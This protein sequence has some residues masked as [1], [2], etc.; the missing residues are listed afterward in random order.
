[1]KHISRRD[2][3]KLIG[4]TTAGGVLAA[5]APKAP[6]AEEPAPAEPAA[7]TATPD[8]SVAAPPAEQEMMEIKVSLWD[9]QNSFPEGQEPDEIARIVSDKFKIKLTPINVGWGDA[10]EKYNTWAASGQ[11]PDIIGAIAMPGT[12]RYY[13]WISDGVVRPLPDAVSYS[14]IGRLMEQ[15][16]LTAFA[17]EGKN[18]F[19]PRQTYGDAA[20]WAMDRGLIA[21]KDWL[22]KL[23]MAAPKTEEDYINLTVALAKNDPDGNGE[24]D[25]VGFVPV[26]PW[27]LLSQGWTG[28]GYT[29]WPWMRDTDGKFRQ[30][31][32]GERT[33]RM[34]QFFKKMFQAGGLDPDFATLESDQAL[35][36]F[37]SGKAGILGRQVSPK[38]LKAVMDSWVKL[39]P[40]KDFVES[41]V[42]LHGPTVDGNYTR[43]SEKAYWSESYIEA[44]VDDAKME[45][46]MQL[47]N[48]LYSK[49]GMY[50]MQFG[51][52]QKDYTIE[53]GKI[54]LLTEINP[55]T[56][57]NKPTYEIYP[58]TYAMSYLAAWTGDLVQYEDPSIPEAIRD[59]TVAERDFRLANWK[60]PKIDWRVQSIDV[61]EKQEMAAIRFDDDW[62]KFIMDTSGKADEAVYEEMKANWDAN[63]Y[64]AAV[65]AIADKAKS[66]GIE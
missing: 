45:R 25:T 8:S 61:P 23:G 12:G 4:L 65:N 11:L 2:A 20:W 31:V 47:Y 3:L 53:N 64:G 18:Y 24:N 30:A 48:F 6:A 39:Q 15:P 57:L 35:E 19:L 66:M 56:G 46:I 42:I 1:M 28:F 58:F 22:D 36:K 55:E 40:D 13:Q 52:D 54:K 34:M 17:V 5:C 26:G 41:I 14:E 50:M 29:D 27:I 51:L 60:D 7:A 9:I 37:A 33:F 21:R 62:V 43:F 49:E 38:H 10:D 44:N 16:E 32:S 59:L 63:G